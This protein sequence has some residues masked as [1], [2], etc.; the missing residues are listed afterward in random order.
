MDGRRVVQYLAALASVA[1]ATVVA[2]VLQQL[3]ASPSLALIFVLPVL[4]LGLTA[5]WGPSLVAALGSVV[6]FD[7][8]FIEPR[9]SLRVDA[10]A[11]AWALILLL[12][13][14]AIAS[15]V[16]AEARRRAQQS[17]L[18]ADRVEVLRGLAQ[19]VVNRA[20]PGA[21]VDGVRDALVAIFDAPAV[22]LIEQGGRLTTAS[23]SPGAVLSSADEAAAQWAIVNGLATHAETFPFD[24]ACF[25][26]WP[27]GRGV[28]LGVGPSA[29]RERNAKEAGRY[30]D[31]VGGYLIAGLAPR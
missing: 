12:V 4:A 6:A 11:D 20:A 16:A 15:A 8:F 5:G 22:V 25:D 14:A 1:A 29:R 26:V 31:L 10:P 17:R 24:T 30:V 18:D 27:V 23:A 21:I 13:V 2:F 19:L 28:A 7:V 3:A 9:F